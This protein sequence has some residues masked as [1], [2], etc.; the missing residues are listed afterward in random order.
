MQ[1]YNLYGGSNKVNF[2]HMKIAKE[3][4]KAVLLESVD[5][6]G[7]YLH[8]YQISI[9]LP[10]KVFNENQKPEVWGGINVTLP[11]YFHVTIKKQQI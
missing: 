11:H 7:S 10:K 6:C 8:D 3:T 1:T 5:S 9:W 2:A 4:D